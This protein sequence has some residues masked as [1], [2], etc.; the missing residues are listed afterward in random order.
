[1]INFNLETYDFILVIKL[2]NYIYQIKY[3]E[4]AFK[5]Y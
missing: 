4:N 1:M 3:N 2:H 5:N